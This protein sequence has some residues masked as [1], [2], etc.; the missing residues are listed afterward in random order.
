MKINKQVTHEL[1]LGKLFISWLRTFGE[2][3]ES[4]NTS[5]VQFHKSKMQSRMFDLVMVNG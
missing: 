5:E 4:I 1:F 2:G 3:H